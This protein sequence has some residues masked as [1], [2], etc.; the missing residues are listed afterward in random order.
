MGLQTPQLLTLRFLSY[1]FVCSC[2]TCA[3]AW[4]RSVNGWDAVQTLSLAFGFI[5][6]KAYVRLQLVF[7]IIKHMHAPATLSGVS[8]AMTE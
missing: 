1:R 5:Y 7:G 2:V 3:P 6:N 4:S 8:N